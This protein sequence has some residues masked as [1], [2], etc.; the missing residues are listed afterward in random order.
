MDD[1]S[2]ILAIAC[3][4]FIT[5]FASSIRSSFRIPSQGRPSW[6]A[7]SPSRPIDV[8]SVIQVDWKFVIRRAALNHVRVY[9]NWYS[10]DNFNPHCYRSFSMLHL[11][12]WF[13][14]RWR[15]SSCTLF[16]SC[17]LIDICSST[18]PSTFASIILGSISFYHYDSSFQHP[19]MNN[20]TRGV[21]RLVSLSILLL[22][23]D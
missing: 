21:Y 8:Y 14:C 3:T 1:I 4:T 17:I 11:L 23:Y 13:H 5:R 15:R 9:F 19:Q 6:L 7:S 16:Y 20:T 12:K 2:T 10:F 22:S 18:F